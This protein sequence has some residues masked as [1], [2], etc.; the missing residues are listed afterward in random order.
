MRPGGDNV[1]MEEPESDDLPIA[2]DDDVLPGTAVPG[3]D[4]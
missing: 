1:A 4:D 2:G 3:D